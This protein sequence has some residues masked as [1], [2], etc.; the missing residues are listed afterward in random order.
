MI[1]TEIQNV[2]KMIKKC[3][4]ELLNHTLQN[5]VVSPHIRKINSYMDECLELVHKGIKNSPE[6]SVR[7]AS[8]FSGTGR[9]NVLFFAYCMSKWDAEFVNSVIGKRLNQSEAFGYL[10]EKLVVKVNTLKNY[11]DT[12]DSHVEQMR[13]N[14]QGWK[15]PLNTEFEN[16]VTQY[17]SHSEKELIAIGKGILQ[18]H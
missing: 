16:I 8:R 4:A 9:D 10:A 13:S 15:K 17:D 3:K 2:E 6:M 12:F 7:R 1:T 11:R 18:E 5:E 14:R